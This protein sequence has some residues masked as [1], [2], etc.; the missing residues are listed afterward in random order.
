MCRLAMPDSFLVM[1]ALVVYSG[2]RLSPSDCGQPN[3]H[4]HYGRD[5]GGKHAIAFASRGIVG[6]PNYYQTRLVYGS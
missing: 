4:F 1:I 3:R 6:L 2:L 5:T